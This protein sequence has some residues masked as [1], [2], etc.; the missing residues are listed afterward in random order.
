MKSERSQAW[1]SEHAW[2][3][4]NVQVGSCRLFASATISQIDYRLESSSLKHSTH[5]E[6]G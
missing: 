4:R 3:G 5:I 6:Q 1:W 2:M